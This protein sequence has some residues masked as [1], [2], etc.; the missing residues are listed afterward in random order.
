MIV[1]F[2]C[3]GNVYRSRLAEAYLNSKKLVNVKVISSGMGASENGNRPIS[4]L[5]QRLFEVYKLV[6]FEK[7]LW[8]QTSKQLLDSADFTIF[9]G[10]EY[11]QDCVKQFN[12]HSKLFEVWDI[13]DLDGNIKDHMEKIRVTEETFN[14]I[15]QKVDDLIEREKFG[16]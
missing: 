9:F 7:P 1:H 2:V 16:L 8:T 12:F 15:R 14:T 4:W 5:T 6:P 11:Y 10:K 13:E 3:F